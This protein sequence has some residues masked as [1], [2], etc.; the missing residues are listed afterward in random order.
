[1]KRENLIGERKHEGRRKESKNE[2]DDKNVAKN[3]NF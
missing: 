2:R 1:M 3:E